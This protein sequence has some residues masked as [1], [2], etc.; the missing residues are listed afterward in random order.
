M[1]GKSADELDKVFD[2]ILLLLGIMTAALFQYESVIEPLRLAAAHPNL[3]QQ[4]LLQKIDM[5]LSLSLRMFFLPLFVL[6]A[7]WLAN[8]LPFRMR[9]SRRN[10][11]SGFCYAFAAAI[12]VFNI[13]VFL[14]VSFPSL[15]SL[16]TLGFLVVLLV[17]QPLISLPLIY[18]REI[19]FIDQTGVR[20][21]W[22]KFRRVWRL[23]MWKDY[24]FSFSAWFALVAITLI[25]MIPLM[26]F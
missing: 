15:S 5:S 14:D 16:S 17:F 4:Q 6:I 2:I 25:N 12:L 3:T 26:G 20:T 10:N 21:R 24:A 8:R 13:Y 1:R 18:F 22:Q 11:I 23:I 7:F 19:A 9:T